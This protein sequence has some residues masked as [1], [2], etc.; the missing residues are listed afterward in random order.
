MLTRSIALSLY[1]AKVNIKLIPLRSS[2]KSRIEKPSLIYNV[3]PEENKRLYRL[4]QRNNLNGD[5]SFLEVCPPDYWRRNKKA[6]KNTGF[7]TFETDSIPNSWKKSLNTIKDEIWVPTKFNQYSFHK[8]GV[9][10]PIFII[11]YGFE[12]NI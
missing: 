5:Y 7:T 9:K 8:N 2:L 4:L 12:A 10:T 11:P 6:N 1:Q 3:M